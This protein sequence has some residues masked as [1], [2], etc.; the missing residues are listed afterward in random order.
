MHFL[1]RIF[2]LIGILVMGS[3]TQQQPQKD[4]TARQVNASKSSD[5]MEKEPLASQTSEAVTFTRN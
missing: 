3:L 5:P 4:A 2:V 1:F